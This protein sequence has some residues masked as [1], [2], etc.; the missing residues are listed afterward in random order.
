MKTFLKKLS[1]PLFVAIFSVL[2]TLGIQQ[3]VLLKATP[4]L[5]K[6]VIQPDLAGLSPEIK[7]QISLVA[8][9]YTLQN[10][11]HSAAKNVSV[12]IKSDSQIDIST[13]KFSQ[14]SEVHQVGL[15]DP[16]EI[17]IDVPSIRPNG[18]VSFQLLIPAGNNVNFSELSDSA[19]IVQTKGNGTQKAL[20]NNALGVGIVVFA[21]II[22]LPVVGTLIYSF[23]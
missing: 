15:S 11:S 5:E 8:V 6:Q 23:R 10:I 4:N 16:H 17:K 14:D 3:Y 20:G 18:A 1:V 12:F 21:T 7:K 2:A 19:V 9:N 13:L 22:W